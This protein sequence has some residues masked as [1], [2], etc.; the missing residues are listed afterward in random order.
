MMFSPLSVG[1]VDKT[2]TLATLA[3]EPYVGPTLKNNGYLSE[4]IR[5]AFKRVGYTTEILFFPWARAVITAEYGD[6]DG[7][8]P[9]YLDEKRKAQFVFSDPFPGG[10]AGLYKRKDTIATYTVN[11]QINQTEALHGLEDFRFG[12]VRG[13][14]NTAEFDAAD[15]LKKEEVVSDELNLKKLYNRRIQFMFI[16]KYVAEYLIKHKFP[17]YEAELE[18][19]QPALE[20]KLL[21]IAFSKQAPGYLDKLAAFNAG[22]QQIQADGTLKMIMQQHGINITMP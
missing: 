18:F 9:E 19:M 16:D 11:P 6:V 12:V 20:N 2:V 3:W 15:F 4:I 13:Y 7:L 22:L 17:E 1:A 10:P 21:Y 8:F 5:E 14:V